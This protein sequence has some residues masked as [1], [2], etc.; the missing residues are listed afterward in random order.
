[1][2][3]ATEMIYPSIWMQKTFFQIA[4]GER[5]AKIG[6]ELSGGSSNCDLLIRVTAAVH[7]VFQ[8]MY[9]TIA[10]LPVCVVTATAVAF[11][12]YTTGFWTKDGT[13]LERVAVAVAAA[14]A[15]LPR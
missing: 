10:V 5:G 9:A 11:N 14:V 13:A 3:I 4:E 12:S 7:A 6:E 1:M 15:G 2:T 8:L